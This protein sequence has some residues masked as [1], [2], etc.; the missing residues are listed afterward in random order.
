MGCGETSQSGAVTPP[1]AQGSPTPEFTDKHPCTVQEA[2]RSKADRAP[3][4][5]RE[6]LQG[7]SDAEGEEAPQHSIISEEGPGADENR[8]GVW[9]RVTQ[10]DRV[11]QEGP[12]TL[13]KEEPEY[14]SLE[15]GRWFQQQRHAER[16]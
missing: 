7:A 1:R 2:A 8:T 13:S 6:L 3:S 10:S 16:P 5:R 12:Q 15:K 11:E 9:P 14:K 4:L